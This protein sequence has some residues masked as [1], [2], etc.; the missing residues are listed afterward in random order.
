MMKTMSEE[1]ETKKRVNRQFVME[2]RFDCSTWI[3]DMKMILFVISWSLND[4]VKY[5]Q[6]SNVLLLIICTILSSFL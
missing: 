2:A 4:N 6:F 3:T 1:E 5:L